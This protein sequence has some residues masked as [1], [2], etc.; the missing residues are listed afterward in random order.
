MQKKIIIAIIINVIILSAGLG[1]IGHL[2]INQSI[3]R[4]LHSRLTLA[5]I[6]ANNI[7]LLL[8]RSLNRLYD[9]SL[10]GKIDLK[11]NN[12]KPEKEALQIAYQYS[13]FTDGI[14]LMDR[15]GNIVLTYPSRLEN[16]ENLLSNPYVSKIIMEGKPVISDI[17]TVEPTG[18]KVIY[19]MVPLKSKHGDIVGVVGG[20]ID[21]TSFRLSQSIEGMPREP[22]TYLEII[23]SHGIIIVSNNPKRVFLSSDHN[24]FMENLIAQKKP[25]IR[26]CHRCHSG[27][28]GKG[29]ERSTDILAFAPLK[30]AHWGVSIIQPEKDVFAPSEKLRTTFIAFS[31]GSICIALIIAIGMSKSIVKPVHKLIDATNKIADGDMSKSIAF[32]GIDEIG[33]LSSSFEVMRVKLA[34]SLEGLRHYNVQLEERVVERTKQIKAS[35]KKVE[36]LL[37]M[38]ISAEEEE[39]KRIARGLHDE[40]MQSLSALLMKID[41]C[42]KMYAEH[43]PSEKIDEMRN[44]AL[45]TL[46][47]IH[48]LIQNL[49]PTVVDDLGLEAGIR[50][51]LD[52][53]LAEKGIACDF[54]VMG[55]EEKRF[56]HRI[57]TALFRI[58]QEAVIN[59]S[60]HASAENVFIV[61]QYMSDSIAVHME[62][63]GK[64]FD[65][66]DVLKH[67]DDVRGLGIM[68]MRERAYLVDGKL[69]IC[70]TPGNGTRLSLW[71]PLP[72]YGNKHV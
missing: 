20:E 17:H 33:I 42:S 61:L 9:I 60:K 3:D 29:D 70:S 46:D 19:A 65:A 16:H 22:N 56:N 34:D 35:Q 15:T 53:H 5:G 6:I 48:S 23:D 63:D 11:D 68:G 10:S 32:G 8:E 40:T 39:R 28:G 58:I 37:K 67:T 44:I 57:E 62:D 14:F 50:W 27:A 12:W 24:R 1:I 66:A 49:R 25:E 41:M 71:I 2:T 54:N 30:M 47:E 59:I 43:L 31:L 26:T 36:N 38:V 21:P 64:G 4:S 69:K 45:K 51:L 13:I 7:D 72:E 55:A 52:K 18:K